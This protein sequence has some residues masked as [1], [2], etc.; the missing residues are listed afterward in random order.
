MPVIFQAGASKAGI[1]L[2][3]AHAEGL[4]CGS[5]APETTNKYVQCICASAA[6]SGRSPKDIKAFA[7]ISPFIGR[8]MEE[9]QAKY[10]R[11]WK[12]AS[13][14]AGLS[15]FGGYTSIDLSHFPLDEPFEHDVSKPAAN[16][17][18]GIL[19]SF[20][21]GDGTNAKWTPRKLG[22][23]MSCG[24]MYPQ[25]VGTPEMVADFMEKWAAESGIDG[26]STIPAVLAPC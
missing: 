15:R 6:A 19:K 4:Y 24:G 1:A 13:A 20:R 25:V 16:A 2:A 22:E 5:I 10:D 17:V 8:T 23:L 12:H 9:A 18:G 11:A 26:K 3:G 7:G 21:A 14:R